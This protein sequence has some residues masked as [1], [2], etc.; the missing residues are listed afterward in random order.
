MRPAADVAGLLFANAPAAWD[1]VGIMGAPDTIRAGS[2]DAVLDELGLS[3]DVLTDPAFPVDFQDTWPGQGIPADSFPVV[4]FSSSVTATS[5]AS[6]RGVLIV[7]GE[8]RPES[9]FTWAGIVLAERLVPL[10][11]GALSAPTYTI[12]G[13]TVVGLDDSDAL[14]TVT[15]GADI[16]YHRCFAHGAGNS[17]AYFRPIDDAWWEAAGW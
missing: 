12:L 6:G 13:V 9:G 3:W 5:A 16:L 11:A 1:G 17:I 2:Y 4:R 14:L 7:Q 15:A 10:T 8:L